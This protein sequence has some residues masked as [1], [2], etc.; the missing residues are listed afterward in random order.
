MNYGYGSKSMKKSTSKGKK[1]SYGNMKKPNAMTSK[2]GNKVT[3]YVENRT[4]HDQKAS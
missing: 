3:G 2:A 1:M 4:D